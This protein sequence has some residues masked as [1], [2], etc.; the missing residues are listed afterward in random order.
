MLK[1]ERIQEHL[2]HMKE[3]EERLAK[4]KEL[5]K[6]EILRRFEKEEINNKFNNYQ[7]EQKRANILKNRDIY[8]QQIVTTTI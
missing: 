5:L 7:K 8:L 2:N 1:D 3:Q 4:E 6:W